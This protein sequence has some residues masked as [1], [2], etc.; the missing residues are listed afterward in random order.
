MSISP[1]TRGTGRALVWGSIAPSELYDDGWKGTGTGATAT[2]T[3]GNRQTTRASVP[4]VDDLDE[5]SSD[6]LFD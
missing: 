6:V 2:A 5:F 3:A 4:A 1:G